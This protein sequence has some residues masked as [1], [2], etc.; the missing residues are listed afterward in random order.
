MSNPKE[1]SNKKTTQC[2]SRRDFLQ[3]SA[4]SL[5][6]VSMAKPTIGLSKTSSVTAIA[7][8]AFPIFDPRPIF[9]KV[10]QEFPEFG[11]AFSTLWRQKIFSYTWL[12]TSANRYIDFW[13]CIQ[14]ALDHT[15]LHFKVQ[16]SGSQR[17]Q[18]MNTFLHLP[19]YSDVIPVL[20]K[21]HGKGIEL[22]F[23]SNMTEEMLLANI[24]ANKLNKYF[25][26]IISTDQAR[27]YKPS[28]KAY[29]LAVETFSRDK[30]EILFT[31]FANWDATGAQW[32]GLPTVWVNRLDFTP[33][34]LT[35]KEI[36]TG[37]SL[38]ILLDFV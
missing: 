1:T 22:A 21:L 27:T 15:A 11:K 24:N 25:K 5:A 28:P 13:S 34:L 38:D 33:D 17:A 18:L 20:E 10:N 6:A 23:L 16:L 19:I 31:A 26:Y 35:D 7:F 36:K 4:L 8:D 9:K 32:F 30:E 37:S 3:L 12:L 14:L 2:L 29:Q